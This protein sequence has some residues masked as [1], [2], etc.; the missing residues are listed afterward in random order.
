MENLYIFIG[1][2]QPEPALKYLALRTMNNSRILHN[3]IRKNPWYIQN[4]HNLPYLPSSNYCTIQ[5]STRSTNL[6][7][8]TLVKGSTT[9]HTSST[10]IKVSHST[11]LV[12]GTGPRMGRQI[13]G[14][15]T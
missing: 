3:T 13:I 8:N 1:Q 10:V 12:Q 2:R 6:T 9:R 4:A 7:D 14:N 15:T 11:I 5:Q